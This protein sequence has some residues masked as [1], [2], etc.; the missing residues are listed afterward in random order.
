MASSLELLKQLRDKTQASISVVKAAL[1]EAEGD[2][3]KAE[4]IL[5]K[6]GFESAAKKASRT[7]GEGLIETYVHGNGK[8]GVILELNCETDFVARTGEFKELAHE[9]A[10][11]VAA[12]NPE[13]VDGL[14]K[15]DYIRDGSKKIGDMVKDSIARVGENIVLKRFK[16]FEIGGE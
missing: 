13:S 10:M 12:M 1:D 8:I 3:K 2:M 15:Q 14:L 16:R 4:E 7:A 9:I 6:K 5:K 11:Q